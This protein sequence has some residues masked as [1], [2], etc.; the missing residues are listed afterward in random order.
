MS[1]KFQIMRKIEI[2]AA[3]R[4]PEHGS[5][6]SKIHGHRYVIE[7]HCAGE[8][9]SAGEETGMVMDFS[10]LKDEM[11]KRIGTIYDHALILCANDK[12]A[13]AYDAYLREPHSTLF[14]NYHHVFINHEHAKVVIVQHAPTAENLARVWYREL[15][16]SVR[17]RTGR[18]A[19][20]AKIVVWETP[21]CCASFPH[22]G[23]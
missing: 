21:N 9:A 1:E 14:G 12:A 4:V 15:Y 18:R 2:D 11:D 13:L 17:E 3:H 20:L 5:K 22:Y 23:K 7:A 10:F 6:C 19:H 8:L 16:Q